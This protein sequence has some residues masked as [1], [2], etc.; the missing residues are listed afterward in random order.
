V[1]APEGARSPLSLVDTFGR[2]HRR[3][4][5]S[6]TDRCNLRCSYCMP[7]Q[8]LEWLAR[9]T[10]LTDDEVVRTVGVMVRT[11]GITHLRLTG[12]EPLLRPGLVELVRR[13]AAI[14][15]RPDLA[16]TTNGIGLSPIVGELRSAGLDRINIS[17]DT[18]DAHTFHTLTRRDRISDVLSGIDAAIASGLTPVKVNTVL[19]RGINDHEAPDLLAFCLDR[20]V[21]LRFIEQMPLDPQHGWNRDEMVTADE[22]HA[23]LARAYVLT[24]VAGRGSAPAEEWLVDG[25][26]HTVGIIGSMTRPFCAACDRLRLTADGQVRSCL[27]A[28][29]ESDLR[30]VLREGGSDADLAAVVRLAVHGKRAGHGVDG[31]GFLQPDRPMSAI[32][33]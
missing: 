7:E 30:A 26:P 18:L 28:R 8:G 22:I 33:G 32:G 15:P 17:L 11:L 19:M 9:D 10:V 1:V 21:Q 2:V 6:L 13:F 12:G 27:F 25:G 23:L 14:S 29:E 5:V 16:L 24:P 3:L 31:P 20:G 4:R